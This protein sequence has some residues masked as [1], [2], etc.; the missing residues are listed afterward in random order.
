MTTFNVGDR[1]RLSPKADPDRRAALGDMLGTV[2]EVRL[3]H[4]RVD[5]DAPNPDWNGPEHYEVELAPA[6]SLV[7]DLRAK[8][9]AARAEADAAFNEYQTVQTAA[10]AADERVY[11]LRGKANALEA[12]VKILE[13]AE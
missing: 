8:A 13:E 7:D 9:T 5:W 4:Y 2:G 12:A 1:V 6:P 3:T 10:D 11:A